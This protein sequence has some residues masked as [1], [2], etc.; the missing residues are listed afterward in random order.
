MS[1]VLPTPL[2]PTMITVVPAGGGATD[3]ILLQSLKPILHKKIRENLTHQNFYPQ[4]RSIKMSKS[5]I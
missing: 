3:T 4:I 2:R 1:A 5:K